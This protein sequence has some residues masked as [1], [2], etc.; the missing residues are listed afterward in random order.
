MVSAPQ[1]SALVFDY[2]CTKCHFK[3]RWFWPQVVPMN[4]PAALRKL[5]ERTQ[6][7]AAAAEHARPEVLL[8]LA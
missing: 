8:G 2:S 6:E 5:A 7:I 4:V 1:T 3:G